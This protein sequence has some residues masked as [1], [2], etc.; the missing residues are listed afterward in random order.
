MYLLLLVWSLIMQFVTKII[1]TTNLLIEPYVW[2]SFRSA[3]S[4]DSFFS[5]EILI[6]ETSVKVPN[7]DIIIIII[8]KEHNH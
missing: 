3:V 5:L 1:V 8:T 4:V 7:Q 6:S 2:Y